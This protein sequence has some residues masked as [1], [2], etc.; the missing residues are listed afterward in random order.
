METGKRVVCRSHSERQEKETCPFCRLPFHQKVSVKK[1]KLNLKMSAYVTCAQCE[2]K[3]PRK[4]T[5]KCFTCGF[6]CIQCHDSHTTMKIFKNHEISLAQVEENCLF[7]DKHKD[8]NNG[9]FC[10]KCQKG[11]CEECVLE[12]HGECQSEICTSHQWLEESVQNSAINRLE[13]PQLIKYILEHLHKI[14]K[15]APSL[16]YREGIIQQLIKLRE[17]TLSLHNFIKKT[18]EEMD[19]NKNIATDHEY[20]S[21]PT[22]LFSESCRT[23][24]IIPTVCIHFDVDEKM[25]RF[26]NIGDLGYQNKALPVSFY[27]K[28]QVTYTSAMFPRYDYHLELIQKIIDREIEEDGN[29]TIKDEYKISLSTIR[30][31]V[32]GSTIEEIREL[33]DP[34]EMQES[35]GNDQ[36]LGNV[37][38]VA[39]IDATD[40]DFETSCNNIQE[41]M[42]ELKCCWCIIVSSM[43]DLEKLR[44]HLLDK[45][46]TTKVSIVPPDTETLWKYLTSA[47][48]LP[49]IEFLN[50]KS[51]NKGLSNSLREDVETVLRRIEKC[52]EIKPSHES[53]EIPIDI[54]NV[55]DRYAKSIVQYGFHFE[56]FRIVVKNGK[57]DEVKEALNATE[58]CDSFAIEVIRQND[59]KE[60][61]IPFTGEHQAQGMK[62]Y[63]SP[64]KQQ[65]SA[66]QTTIDRYGT[67]GSLALLNN[68]KTVALSCRHICI[69]GGNVFFENEQN[70]RIL[71]GTCINTSEEAQKIYNDLAIFGLDRDVEKNFPKKKLL[72]HKGVLT[73][74]EVFRSTDT[75]GIRGEIVHKLGASSK[76]TQGKIVASERV[77]N[78]Y[79][80]IKVRGMNGQEF[81]KPG[82]SGSI[83]FRESQDARERKL[84][85]VAIL[86]GGQIENGEQ[87]N[88]QTNDENSQSELIVCTVFKDALEL[89]KKSNSSIKSLEFFND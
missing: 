66:S 72:N 71:L 5:K 73:N 19:V 80:I 31:H 21:L 52:S 67:L 61:I 53:Y 50:V 87:L 6:L 75:F 13:I 60:T 9:S 79:S 41:Q 64:E 8:T 68:E 77:E 69:K 82:D 58:L 29:I 81:G 32:Y 30:V 65:N 48:E 89:I 47:M 74:A 54:K 14:E 86:V 1:E 56:N 10:K 38:L 51:M 44:K 25:E 78:V 27:S 88:D 40:G 15:N 76:W 4:A 16:T 49:L 43:H 26:R 83:V 20:P 7:C 2:K 11:V 28:Y 62:L 70:E 23:A 45:T 36:Y 22:E 3:L 57:F 33:L 85:V 46:H 24:N 55:L 12:S 35:F 59:F 18:E 39:F 17:S 63:Q 42:N 34:L 84:E 37:I